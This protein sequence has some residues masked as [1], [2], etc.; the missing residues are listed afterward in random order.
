MCLLYTETRQ[1]AQNPS[2]KLTFYSTGENR[3]NGG[4]LESPPIGGQRA[5]VTRSFS[6]TPGFSRVLDGHAIWKPFQRFYHARQTVETVRRNFE[7]QVTGLK[8]GVNEN[9]VQ[10]ICSLEC[11]TAF[12]FRWNCRR[13]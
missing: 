8:P 11:L 7:R 4:W 1:P 10:K 2:H 9:L 6:L 5:I 12:N 3:E 13:A